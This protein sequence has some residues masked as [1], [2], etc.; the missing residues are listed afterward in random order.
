MIKTKLKI[1]MPKVKEPKKFSDSEKINIIKRFISEE[2]DEIHSVDKELNEYNY[3]KCC[4]SKIER[5]YEN[6]IKIINE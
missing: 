4:R 3:D 5:I 6:I 2:Y 1:P